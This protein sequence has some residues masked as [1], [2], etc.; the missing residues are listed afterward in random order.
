M[1]FLATARTTDAEADLEEERTFSRGDEDE[2]SKL[3]INPPLERFPVLVDVELVVA[4]RTRERRKE[5]DETLRRN[6]SF[7]L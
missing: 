4:V 5:R 6:M 1:S 2:F 7:V 3:A